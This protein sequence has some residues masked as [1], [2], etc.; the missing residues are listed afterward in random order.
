[1]QLL[2]QLSVGRLTG[3]FDQTLLDSLPSRW[4][5]MRRLALAVVTLQVLC[6]RY[7]RPLLDTQRLASSLDSIR[8]LHA[9]AQLGS[10]TDEGK[11]CLRVSRLR[12]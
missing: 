2:R 1:M 7:L 5:C 8:S 3:P 11:V 9:L 6:F 10:R 4:S 12:I